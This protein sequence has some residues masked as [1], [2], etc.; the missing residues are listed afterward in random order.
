MIGEN[1]NKKKKI[2]EMKKKQTTKSC[3]Y[4]RPGKIPEILGE[5]TTVAD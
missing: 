2:G 3:L 1:N 5:F 4:Y